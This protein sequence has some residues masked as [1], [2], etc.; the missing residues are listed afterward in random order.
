MKSQGAV[1]N[2]RTVTSCSVQIFHLH[3]VL[4]NISDL[5]SPGTMLT[6]HCHFQPE[7]RQHVMHHT[8]TQ[9]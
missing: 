9:V 6:M 3:K 4:V 8:D 1:H 5:K 2:L 7:Q